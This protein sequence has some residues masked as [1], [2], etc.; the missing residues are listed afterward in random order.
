M[1]KLFLIARHEF[2]H[3]VHQRSFLLTTLGLPLLIVLIGLVSVSTAES[4]VA[5]H[6]IGY[7]DPDSVLGNPA[8]SRVY[9]GDTEHTISAYDDRTKAEAAVENGEI[10]ALFVVGSSYAQDGALQVVYWEESPS[11]T[12]YSIWNQFARQALTANYDADVAS[13]LTWGFNITGESLSGEEKFSNEG[14]PSF[15]VAMVAAILFII[16]SLMS[17]GYLLQAVVGEKEN[18][19]IEVMASTVTPEQLVGGKTLGLLAVALAQI[20]VWVLS[21][22]LAFDM[23]APDDFANLTFDLG[24]L[25]LLAFYFIPSFALLGGMMVAIGAASTEARQAQ[26]LSGPISMLFVLPLMLITLFFVA[27]ESPIV[28]ALTLFPTTSFVAV[29]VLMSMGEVAVWQIVVGQVLL[30]AS[31]VGMVWVAARVFRMGM[32]RTGQRLSWQ[33]IRVGLR[34]GNVS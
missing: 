24:N 33:Q 20:A 2:M 6:A 9:Y 26:Q 22:L 14:I 34:G 32:L 10:D 12:V 27:P 30:W 11:D 3:M 15:V 8:I 29:A 1:K 19:T 5:A 16:A 28:M 31:A 17:S 21:G 7:F 25:A 23:F 13:R 4:A 18:R